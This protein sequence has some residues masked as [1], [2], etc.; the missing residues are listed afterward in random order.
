MWESLVC[1]LRG[2]VKDRSKVYEAN[3]RLI[4][5]GEASYSSIFKDYDLKIDFFVSPFLVR[6]WEVRNKDGSMKE[7]L[8]LDLISKSCREYK[9]ADVIIFNTGHWW[10]HDKTSKGYY[11]CRMLD[12]YNQE[13][14]HVYAE[15]NVLEAY[16]RALMTWA[17]WVDANIDPTKTL[18]FFRGYSDSHFSGGQWNSGGQCDSET[19]PIKNSAYLRGY[20]PKMEE[21]ENVLKGMK[22]PVAYL[23]VTEMTDY[24]K[25]GHPSIYRKQHLTNAERRSPLKYQDCSH[26]CLPGVPDSWNEIF[27]T[28]LLI[29]LHDRELREQQHRGQQKRP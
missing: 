28:E 29:K 23:N 24:R 22:T 2:A 19:E 20:P 8:R 5:R 25:D 11:N 9:G 26:W 15:L 17:K 4:F 1:I 3:G 27:Y 12:G 7:T 16:R 14:N 21:L 13:G 18:V 6:E 10:T